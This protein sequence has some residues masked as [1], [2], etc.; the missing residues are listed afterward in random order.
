M[1]DAN[2][3]SRG[4]LFLLAVVASALLLTRRLVRQNNQLPAKKVAAELSSGP[5]AVAGSPPM[6]HPA[7]GGA[8]QGRGVLMRLLAVVLIALAAVSAWYGVTRHTY[9]GSAPA[10]D[11]NHTLKATNFLVDRNDVSAAVSL[12]PGDRTGD[13]SKLGIEVGVNASAGET[14]QWSLALAFGFA[15]SPPTLDFDTN[16]V[17][18]GVSIAILRVQDD[19]GHDSIGAVYDLRGS[20]TGP[21]SGYTNLIATPGSSTLFGPQGVSHTIL[22]VPGL[23]AAT[24]FEVLC[25]GAAGGRTGRRPRCRLAGDAELSGSTRGYRVGPQLPNPP[26]TD[27]DRS[28]N[29]GGH[30]NSACLDLGASAEN[31]L[32]KTALR[33]EAR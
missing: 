12:D 15:P 28:P 21:S 7:S 33:C 31:N 2:R 13:G 8:E 4:G 9:I 16:A 20:V 14:V 3:S 5:T 24:Y 11:A 29:W 22:T 27:R 17:S 23:V 10:A 32:S 1:P 18:S 26:A 30:R 25:E 19:T 6:Q